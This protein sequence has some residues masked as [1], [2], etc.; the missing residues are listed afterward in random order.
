VVAIGASAGGLEAFTHLLDVFPAQ[1]GMAFIFVQHLDPT[2]KSM[3]A[4][5]LASHTRMPVRE[6]AAN[7]PIEPDTVYIIAPGTYLAARDGM[8]AVSAPQARHGARMPF[9]FLLES[10]A[11]AYGER[12]VG[13]VLSGNGA[14]GSHGL[15]MIANNGGLVI[16]QDPDEAANAGMPQNAI[17][18]GAVDLILP[19]KI[20]P[21]SLLRYAR[22]MRFLDG[23]APAGGILVESEMNQITDLLRKH[24]GQDFSAYKPGTVMRRIGRRMAIHG[25]NDFQSYLTLAVDSAKELTFLSKDLLIHVTSFFRD[26]EVFKYLAATIIPEMVAAHPAGQPLRVW[27][28]AC[29]SGEEVYSLAMLFLEE[30]TSAKKVFKLQVFGSDIDDEAV[31]TARAGVYPAAIMDTVSPERLARFFVP[32]GDNYRILPALRETVIFTTQDVLSDPPFARIDLVSCRNLLIYLLPEAQQRVLALLHFALTANGILLLGSAEST[33]ALRS[34]FEPVSEDLRLYR[35]GGSGR[36]I[37]LQLA[38]GAGPRAFW[39]RQAQNPSPRDLS[40]AEVSRRQLLASYAPASV[41][42]DQN[43]IARHYS[44]ATDAYLQIQAGDANH[45]LLGMARE[46]L[47]SK[48]RVALQRARD[49]HKPV[50]VSGGTV[51]RGTSRVPVRIEARPVEMGDKGFILVSFIDDPDRAASG[52]KSSADQHDTPRT[53]ELEK[54]VEALQEE[55][56]ETARELEIAGADHEAI[57]EEAQSLNEEHQST[58]E[59]L[60]TSKEELQSLNEELTALNGQL[61]ATVNHQRG[62]ADD[63]ENIL[64]SSELAIV[65]LDIDLNIRF[66]SSAAKGLLNAIDTDIGRPIRDLAYRFEDGDLLGDIKSVI[67]KKVALTREIRSHDGDWYSR[68]ILP[69]RPN[70]GMLRGVVITFANISL[71]K[72]GEVRIEEAL[73]YADSVTDAVLQP[74]V[75]LDETL[76]IVSNNSSFRD[77]LGLKVGEGIGQ[78]LTSA[79]QN[80]LDLPAMNLFLDRARAEAAPIEN[81]QMDAVLPRGKR[82]LLLTSRR[83]PGVIAAGKRML[84]AFDDVTERNLIKETLENAKAKAEKANLGKSRFLAAASHDLRQPLQTLSLLHGVLARKLTDADALSLIGKLDET[85][86]AM[87]GMLDTL[88]D[89]NQLEAGTVQPEIDDFEIGPILESLKTEFSYVAKAKGIAIE[90]AATSLRLRTDPLLLTQM[91]ACPTNRSPLR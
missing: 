88:L 87:S 59:E 17:A 42:V 11:D 48:L 80:C 30:I 62:T 5:L 53:V 40:Y 29:S 56:H 45:G 37:S 13:I 24:I 3:I 44:G 61:S 60:E 63:L 55:L 81:F 65:F 26:P 54:I 34:E 46:G 12:A 36:R 8:L 58:N 70:V 14:D 4:G 49:E 83:I 25:I 7:M 90:T 85:L 38:T 32:D 19:I 86:G 79:A 33:G 43:Q 6:A 57:N 27:V 20:I 69:Y 71:M 2:H 35:R 89:I 72:A 64:R 66:F 18:T 15:R 39:P 77:L 78:R 47:R 73:S 51:K 84:I 31:A 21:E 16:A 9:D 22:Q 50:V 67:Q 74:M 82:E 10:L 76:S 1:S 68:R 52:P 28:P 41:L 23:Q 91:K 75:V